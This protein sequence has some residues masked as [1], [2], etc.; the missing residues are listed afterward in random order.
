MP[1]RKESYHHGNLAEALI[2]AAIE[3]IDESGVEHLSIREVARRVGVSPA[4][5]FRHFATK[6]ALLT[7]IAEEAMRRFRES[8]ASA[9]DS[10]D[11]A[12]PIGRLE[13]IGR[14]YLRW[15]ADNPTHFQIISSR[16]LIAFDSTPSLVEANADLRRILMGEFEQAMR[17][18]C[19]HDNLDPDHLLL[20]MRALAYG[21]AR[22]RCDGHLGDWGPDETP[23]VATS[24]ALSQFLTLLR[25]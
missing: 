1:V 18:G 13:A 4:A 12:D 10:V 7:A 20:T 23:D 22:M 5:P 21:L 16:V 17:L 9:L 19:I 6:T 24:A 3:L 11:T 25:R 14:A 15:A 2:A 8:V